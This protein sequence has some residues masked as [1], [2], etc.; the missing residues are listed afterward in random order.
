MRLQ[1]PWPGRGWT[2]ARARFGKGVEESIT[3]SVLDIMSLKLTIIHSSLLQPPAV[4]FLSDF[5][6]TIS[7][8]HTL[9]CEVGK[10]SLLCTINEAGVAHKR[11]PHFEKIF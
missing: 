3:I 5:L 1:A 11:K 8:R 4:Y 10:R 9:N 7:L 6:M 2:S